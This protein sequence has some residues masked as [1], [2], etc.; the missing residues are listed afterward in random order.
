MKKP[1]VPES[2]SE[3]ASV[4]IYFRDLFSRSKFDLIF[5]KIS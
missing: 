2:E 5:E 4:R 1:E 3:K